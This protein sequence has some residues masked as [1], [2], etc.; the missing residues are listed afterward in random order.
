MRMRGRSDA[1]PSLVER[2]PSYLLFIVVEGTLNVGFAIVAKQMHYDASHELCSLHAVLG[3]I[4]SANN[5]RAAVGVA[6]RDVS[7]YI[8]RYST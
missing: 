5:V 7:M 4:P 2:I 6:T 1:Q 8:S 3:P